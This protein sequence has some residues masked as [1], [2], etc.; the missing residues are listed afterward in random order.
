MALFVEIWTSGLRTLEI[1]KFPPL[2]NHAV[3][4]TSFAANLYFSLKSGPVALEPWKSKNFLLSEPR[5]LLHKFCCKLVLFAEIWT[6]GFRTLEIQKFP[7]LR[8]HAVYDT[9][10][11]ANWRF[12]L[13]SGPVALEPW[14]SKN[15]LLSGTTRFITQ[16]LLQIGAFR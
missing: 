2:R 1:R 14:K 13:K 15:F 6:N 12:S 4:Y 16:V 7:P 5:G 3:Y 9:G 10:F 11:A 8:N